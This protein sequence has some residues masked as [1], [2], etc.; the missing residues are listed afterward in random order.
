MTL[1]WVFQDV[2]AS[3]IVHDV[4]VFAMLFGADWLNVFL[5]VVG[6]WM[7]GIKLPS[8]RRRSKGQHF[9]RKRFK[10]ANHKARRKDP[11]RLPLLCTCA[12]S[13][14]ENQCH[15][16]KGITT[17]S[18]LL[19]VA[20]PLLLLAMHLATSSNRS[21]VDRFTF[22]VAGRWPDATYTCGFVV[23]R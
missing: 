1:A 9:A 22:D 16:N 5:L 8:I 15:I 13:M 14:E 4:K 10:C 6:S 11:G 19:L 20:K 17:S 3:D 7:E 2:T 21:S 18:F 23:S 12:T